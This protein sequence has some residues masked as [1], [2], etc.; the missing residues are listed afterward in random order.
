MTAMLEDPQLN[1][2]VAITPAA[3][4]NN[5]PRP[6]RRRPTKKAAPKPRPDHYKVICI[7]TYTKD[8][9]QLDAN[10]AELKRRGKTKMTRSELIRVALAKL[11]LDEVA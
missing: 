10:V 6:R 7:S 8:L 1:G 4:E 3:N 5:E 2:P 9:A 11:D